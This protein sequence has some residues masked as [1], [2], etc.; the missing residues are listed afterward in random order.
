MPWKVNEKMLL[1]YRQMLPR[2]E[3]EHGINKVK[4]YDNDKNEKGQMADEFIGDFA[5]FG[6]FIGVQQFLLIDDI[7]RLE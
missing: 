1:I 3:F 6:K 4:K 2:K 5:P 7:K